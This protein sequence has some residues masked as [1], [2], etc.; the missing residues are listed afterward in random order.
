MAHAI[1]SGLIF[2]SILASSSAL[3]GFEFQEGCG[4]DVAKKLILP[5]E[6]EGMVTLN[7]LSFRQGLVA[8]AKRQAEMEYHSYDRVARWV[9]A[10]VNGRDNPIALPG[11]PAPDPLIS[12]QQAMEK[13]IEESLQSVHGDERALKVLKYFGVYYPGV[14]GARLQKLARALLIQ[15]YLAKFEEMAM[16]RLSMLVPFELALVNVSA[17]TVDAVDAQVTE[18]MR[19]PLRIE[20]KFLS[21]VRR[22]PLRTHGVITDQAG[23]V[24]EAYRLADDLALQAAKAKAQALS[25]DPGVPDVV[26]DFAKWYLLGVSLWPGKKVHPLLVDWGAYVEAFLTPETQK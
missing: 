11:K 22:L 5:S 23:S 17:D 7:E 9:E 10:Y 26:R 1:Q 18:E 19:D 13:A 4:P 25:L 16:E 8:A 6:A 21:L 2:I 12:G 3:A 20:D 14:S 24:D 15:C